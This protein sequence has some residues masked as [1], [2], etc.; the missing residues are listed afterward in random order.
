MYGD[1]W[2]RKVFISSAVVAM[3]C[4]QKRKAVYGDRW[5][6][7]V[8]ISSAVAA[9]PCRQKRKEV[10]VKT[11]QHSQPYT[12]GGCGSLSGI[13]HTL[14]SVQLQ[15]QEL[16][17]VFLVPAFAQKELLGL[18]LQKLKTQ[19]RQESILRSKK[20]HSSVGQ[21]N[22]IHLHN[23]CMLSFQGSKRVSYARRHQPTEP[24]N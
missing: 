4:R 22:S 19:A 13:Q 16:R 17:A 9:M 11:K 1:R 18:F 23:S 2:S 8:F 15:A 14:L 10:H 5:S 3:P 21:L 7:K 24:D 6:R 20:L 12:K